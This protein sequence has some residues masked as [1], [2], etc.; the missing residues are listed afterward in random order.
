MYLLAGIKQNMEELG[1][2]ILPPWSKGDPL[3]FIRVN[4]E[5]I[6]Y[7]FYYIFDYF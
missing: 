2:I 3:E 7:L 6:Y 1:D 4:R 5:V